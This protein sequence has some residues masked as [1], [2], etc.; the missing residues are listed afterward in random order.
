[1]SQQS[2]FGYILKEMKTG[3]P[4]D[5]WTAMFVVA[6][7][8]IIMIWK[9]LMFQSVDEQILEKWHIYNGVLLSHEIVGNPAFCDNME[10]TWGHF[11][12]WIISAR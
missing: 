12:K 8:T 7:F 10:G 1:M 4:R 3:S 11:A 5:I 6:L 2:H 9:Q